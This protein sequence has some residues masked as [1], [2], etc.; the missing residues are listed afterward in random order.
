MRI[1]TATR[2]DVG[3]WLALAKEVEFLFG[4]MVNEP[5]FHAALH[6]NIDRETAYCIREQDGN[7]GTPLMGGMLFSAKP[8]VYHIGWLS[9]AGRGRRQGVG[10]ALV[11]HAIGLVKPPAELLVETFGEDNPGGLPARRLYERLGFEPFE[12][13][14]PGP[15]GG[16]REV[17]RM[18]LE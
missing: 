2:D 10:T 12:K 7:P 3:S 11:E 9:V 4:P 17:F 1:Q 16:S 18:V 6:K 15:E 8:P 13:S 14:Q 5:N